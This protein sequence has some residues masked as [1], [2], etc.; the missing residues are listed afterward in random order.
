[1]G[2]YLELATGDGGTRGARRI[3]GLFGGSGL[4]G[5][6]RRGGG[7]GG[8]GGVFTGA[9]GRR[10]RVRRSRSAD[11]SGLLQDQQ[12]IRNQRTSI[13]GLRSNVVQF[14]QTLKENLRQIPDD[15]TEVV[16]NRLQIAQARQN[17]LNQEFALVSAQ[18]QYQ[19][20]DR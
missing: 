7:F 11:F 15:A 18:A 14:Q 20:P 3:G 9:A 4:E 2:F 12:N 17:L 6:H 5:F 8:V 1:M 13:A 19:A 10:R 16:R